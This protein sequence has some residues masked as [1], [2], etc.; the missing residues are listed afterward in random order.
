[1]ETGGLLMIIQSKRVW[2]QNIFMPAQ[3]EIENQKIKQ[4]LEY[5]QKPVDVDYDNQRIV[6]GFIDQ[7][8]R[9]SVV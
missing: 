8:D 1:M 6:P 3:I 7:Q 2:I 4:I 9:K 5:G